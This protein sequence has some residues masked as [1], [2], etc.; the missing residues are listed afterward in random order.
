MCALGLTSGDGKAPHPTRA[1][2]MQ[3]STPDTL[4][5]YASSPPKSVGTQCEQKA[6][7]NNS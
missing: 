3:R 4:S 6:E 5:M 2:P 7:E 1:L